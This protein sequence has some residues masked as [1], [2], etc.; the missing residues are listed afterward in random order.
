MKSLIFVEG[1]KDIE[2]IKENNIK[3]DD[4]KIIS[5]DII[6]HQK[7]NQMNVK[8]SLVEEFFEDTDGEEI[9][10]LSSNFATTWY[11]QTINNQLK[12]HNLEL[13]YLIEAEIQ[14]YFLKHIRKVVGIKRIIEKE[15]PDEIISF[16]SNSFVKNIIDKTQIQINQFKNY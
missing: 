14:I 2:Y 16:S 5:F 6:A 8:H 15:K 7:L 13:G 9:D 12:Y 1:E 4:K 10:K 3:I 11:K